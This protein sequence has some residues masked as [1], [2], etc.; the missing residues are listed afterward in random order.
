MSSCV[1]WG[2]FPSSVCTRGWPVTTM[3]Q[4][5]LPHSKIPL[6]PRA[7]GASEEKGGWHSKLASEQGSWLVEGRV[8]QLLA[9][10]RGSVCLCLCR[11]GSVCRSSEQYTF[12]PFKCYNRRLGQKKRVEANRNGK[13]GERRGEITRKVFYVCRDNDKRRRQMWQTQKDVNAWWHI[14]FHPCTELCIQ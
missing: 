8:Q 5:Q 10:V 6:V 11:D 12:P 1:T 2:M 3:C 4:Q 7:D 13:E 9:A 14:V